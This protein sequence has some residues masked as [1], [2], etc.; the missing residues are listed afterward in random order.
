MIY[1]IISS[2]L[3]SLEKFDDL[4]WYFDVS[5]VSLLKFNGLLWILMWAQGGLSI[6]LPVL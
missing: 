6:H 5:L 2:E 3:V 1:F 4:I